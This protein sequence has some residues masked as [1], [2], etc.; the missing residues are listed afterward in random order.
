MKQIITKSLRV[1][2]Y[3]RFKRA[4]PERI[5]YQDLVETTR[6]FGLPIWKR[7]L[8]KEI[9]PGHVLI[10]VGATGMTGWRSKFA[11]YI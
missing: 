5:R 6:L 10:E 7:T 3:D 4:E 1:Q 8:D 11:N 2:P 9:V